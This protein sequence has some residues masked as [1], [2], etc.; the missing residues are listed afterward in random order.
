[1]NDLLAGYLDGD[2]SE[3]E[4]ARFL[5]ALEVDPELEGRLRAHERLLALTQR[6]PRHR[7]SPEFTGSVLSR[8][9]GRNRVATR[10][11]HVG[12]R[13]HRVARLLAAA[14]SIVVIFGAGWWGSS[15]RNLERGHADTRLASRASL[16][17]MPASWVVQE[18]G[19]S[20]LVAVRLA[21]TPENQGVRSVSVAGSFND[22]NPG[23]VQLRPEGGAWTGVLI[24]PR[25]TYDYMFIENGDS[26]VPDPRASVTRDDGFGGRNAVLDLRI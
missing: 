2:L 1:M 22:W 17:V 3:E 16:E 21:H 9:R 18:E 12:V 4:A 26:W 5:A 23:E 19:A 20:E 7:T 8:I 13:Q 24:L 14:A 6:L 25:D 11:R 10:P 15:T